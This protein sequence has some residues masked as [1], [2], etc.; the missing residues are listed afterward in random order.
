MAALQ[1]AI[2]G[3]NRKALKPTTTIVT[4][5]IGLVTMAEES[6]ADEAEE[7]KAQGHRFAAGEELLWLHNYRTS[8][9]NQTTSYGKEDKCTAKV[10]FFALNKIN[11]NAKFDEWLY[12]LCGHPGRL[13]STDPDYYYVEQ[14]SPDQIHDGELCRRQFDLLIFPGM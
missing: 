2:A 14:L 12:I 3:F 4:S 8:R 13:H 7:L 10:G 1:E 6:E 5:S 11:H 9:K